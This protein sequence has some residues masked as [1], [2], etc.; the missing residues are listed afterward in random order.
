MISIS[1]IGSR[2]V[3]RSAQRSRPTLCLSRDSLLSANLLS[4]NL[5]SANLLS[6]S[7]PSAKLRGDNLLGNSLLGDLLFAIALLGI[8]LLGSGCAQSPPTVTP[9]V[10]SATGVAGSTCPSAQARFLS[11]GNGVRLVTYDER[12]KLE[13]FCAPIA[14]LEQSNRGFDRSRPIH[15]LSD[16]T[17]AM[18]SGDAGWLL[19]PKEAELLEAPAAVTVWWRNRQCTFPSGLKSYLPATEPAAADAGERARRNPGQ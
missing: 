4:A 6:A 7:L 12:L 11:C 1:E 8:I 14:V 2:G 5:L 13:S 16:G 9:P 3:V 17:R 10:A 18:A 15:R 19:F